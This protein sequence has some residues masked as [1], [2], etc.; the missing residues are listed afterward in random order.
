[1]KEPVGKRQ[2]IEGRYWNS[3][4]HGMTIIAVITH[5]IDWAAYIGADDGREEEACIR[6]AVDYGAK[7][8]RLDAEHFFPDIK[9][10]YRS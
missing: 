5:G 4:G 9:L 8:S 3:G 10:S 1:M 7:L 2:T 6:N